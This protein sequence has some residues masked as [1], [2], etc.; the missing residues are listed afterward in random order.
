MD[1]IF[2]MESILIDRS[3]PKMVPIII[4]KSDIKKEFTKNNIQI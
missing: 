1:K 3:N 2:S 4:E